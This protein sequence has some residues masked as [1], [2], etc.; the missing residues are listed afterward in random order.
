MACSPNDS[1]GSVS[2]D[3]F[4][5]SAIRCCFVDTGSG[6]D[7]PALFPSNRSVTW[8]S[9]PS[10]GPGRLP[11][12]RFGG[13]MECSDVLRPWRRAP[14]PSLGAT[15][16]CG[17][18][19]APCGP[20]RQPRAGGSSSGPPYRLLSPG[21][22]QDLPGSWGTLVSLCRVLRPRQDRRHQACTVCRRGPRYVHNEG[23]PHNLPFEA[24]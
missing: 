23:S 10:P 17:C 15:R 13:T 18:R 7:A 4:A 2:G 9:L 8:H 19:F 1:S 6:F 16:R 24:P 11:F 22:D 12:P 14:L 3:C 21:D 20:A 5:S